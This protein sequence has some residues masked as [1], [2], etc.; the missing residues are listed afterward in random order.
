M[1]LDNIAHVGLLSYSLPVA[2]ESI[3]GWKSDKT[4][5]KLGRGKPT[6]VS[7]NNNH[8]RIRLYH[9]PQQTGFGVPLDSSAGT[10]LCFLYEQCQGQNGT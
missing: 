4:P 10:R 6:A 9:L 8:Q 2:G 3:K 1:R 7:A 5:S